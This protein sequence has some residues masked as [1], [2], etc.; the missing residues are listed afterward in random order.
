MSR[1]RTL[2]SLSSSRQT[3]SASKVSG[4]SHKRADHQFAAGLDAL[5]DGDFAFARQQLDRAHLAQ[6]H[7]HRIVGA[8]ILLARLAGGGGERLAAFGGGGKVLAL[9]AFFLPLRFR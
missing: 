9:G 6:I 4:L 1:S 8:V 5:G 7:A 3:V 2:P